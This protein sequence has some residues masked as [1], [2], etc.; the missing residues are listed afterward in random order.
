MRCEASD[1]RR[2][3]P[4]LLLVAM[5][6]L[7]ACAGEATSGRSADPSPTFNRGTVLIDTGDETVQLH[8]LFA[9]TDQQREYGLMN[10]E[11]FP[12][13]DGMVF[14]FFEETSTGFWMK[15]TLI[16]LSIAFFD[17][18]GKI[19]RILDM[20]PCPSSDDCP[21][22]NPGVAYRGALEVNEGAFDRLGVAVGDTVHLVPGGE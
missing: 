14:V 19:L 15:N 6:A 20:T 4:V 13:D 3:A 9:Q 12:E 8:A 21:I 2:S 5:L 7:S 18:D 22:Y 16:P 11:S 10:R 17:V 1:M